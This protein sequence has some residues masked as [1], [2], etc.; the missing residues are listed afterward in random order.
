MPGTNLG[1]SLR[2]T[3]RRCRTARGMAL[4]GSAGSGPGGDRAGSPT[5]LRQTRG[6]AIKAVPARDRRGGKR[7]ARATRA[8][9]LDPP[10]RRPAAGRC[11]RSAILHHSPPGGRHPDDRSR[12]ATEG[13]IAM[14]VSRGASKSTRGATTPAP[15]AT[16]LRADRSKLLPTLVGASILFRR[17]TS[18]ARPRRRPRCRP[19]HDRASPVLHLRRCSQVVQRGSRRG[20]GRDRQRVA[21][22]DGEIGRLADLQG[23]GLVL[24][25]IHGELPFAL[26]AAC[27]PRLSPHRP[28]VTSREPP[29]LAGRR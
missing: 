1:A 8:L 6:V 13:W 29:H 24:A 11:G 18:R 27:P 23:A 21:I 26:P 19:Q 28:S 15:K 3:V 7:L 9:R 17:Q 25:A 12:K 5:Q 20:G 22:D 4:G 10:E 16:T 2:E 14:A